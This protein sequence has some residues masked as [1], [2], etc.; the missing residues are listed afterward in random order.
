MNLTEW[1]DSVS[2]STDVRLDHIATVDGIE[3]VAV[4]RGRATRPLPNGFNSWT[5]LIP[6]L[7]DSQEL[8]GGDNPYAFI[9]GHDWTQWIET[10][11]QN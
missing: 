10:T 9:R 1:L 2:D 4:V 5:W 11:R 6:M 3:N 8:L 7:P